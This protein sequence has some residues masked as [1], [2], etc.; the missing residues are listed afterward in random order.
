MKLLLPLLLLLQPFQAFA[1]APVSK[2]R[3]SR[4][5]H[6]RSRWSEVDLQESRLFFGGGVLSHQ[7]GRMSDSANGALSGTGL[8]FP[9]LNVQGRWLED[10]FFGPESVAISASMAATPLAHHSQDG[11]TSTLMF[12]PAVRL[13]KCL[14]DWDAGLGFALIIYRVSGSGGV[15]V[16]G[17]GSNSQ[18]FVLPSG[19]STAVYSAID[20]GAGFGFWKMRADLDLMLSGLLSSR[21][22]ADLQLAVSYGVL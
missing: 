20:L 1:V 19:A 8:V 9:T 21:R 12:T 4:V 6:D 11:A 18:S 15:S 13:S 14:G 2:L 5:E 3:S 7:P 10:W 22:S 17:G 16:Q